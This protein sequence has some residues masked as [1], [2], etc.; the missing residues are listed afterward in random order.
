MLLLVEI[1]PSRA[2]LIQSPLLRCRW[3]TFPLLAKAEELL[4]KQWTDGV[5]P[6]YVMVKEDREKRFRHFMS[7]FDPQIRGRPE[8]FLVKSDRYEDRPL[9]KDGSNRKRPDN[10]PRHL[11]EAVHIPARVLRGP[12]T[13]ELLEKFHYLACHRARI[14]FDSTDNEVSPL[15]H[16]RDQV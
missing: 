12:W 11:F 6:R 7:E 15:N 10:R 5:P 4:R 14:D 13:P 9:Y 8:N 1:S 16:T 3:A 2:D